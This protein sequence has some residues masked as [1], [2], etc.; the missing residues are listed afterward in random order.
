VSLRF[1]CSSWA[2]RLSA[3]PQHLDESVRG[4]MGDADICC[5]G[6]LPEWTSAS[7]LFDSF[8]SKPASL[9]AGQD[10]LAWFET[11]L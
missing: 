5:T 7:K 1:Y 9:P 8:L 2:A 10:G 6:E 11:R 3:L 4:P